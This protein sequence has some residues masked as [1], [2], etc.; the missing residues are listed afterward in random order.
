MSAEARRRVEVE[1]GLTVSAAVTVPAGFA[2][3]ET[4]AVL[5]AHG[6]GNDMDSPFMTR[7]HAALAARGLLA[8]RFNFPYTEAGRKAPDRAPRLEQTWRA[9][10][11]WLRGH[12]EHPPG[13][14]FA[15]GK[16][17]GGRMASHLAAAGEPFAGLV[18]LGYPLHPPRQPG[19]L[20]AEHLSRI[21]VPMLFV[22]GTRDPLC[23]LAL[24]ERALVDV[25]APV[26]LHRVE[27]GDHSFKLP[28]RAGRSEEEV[29]EEVA[30]VVAAW[31]VAQA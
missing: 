20:R 15:G 6:A 13:P 7:I 1:P 23:D 10:A 30:D 22:Q 8:A 27:E 31:V 25:T 12:P 19:K 29:L 4:P 3:G 11:A 24:L 2:P 9:V 26:R 18:F 28:K 17:M 14:L 5:L 21:R 16:S